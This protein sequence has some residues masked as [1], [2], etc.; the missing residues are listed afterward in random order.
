M[1]EVEGGRELLKVYRELGGSTK[2]ALYDLGDAESLDFASY[3]EKR[4]HEQ[5]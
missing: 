2:D 3:I 4:L 5:E 1:C